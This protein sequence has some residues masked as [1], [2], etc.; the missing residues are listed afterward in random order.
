MIGN[1]LATRGLGGKAMVIGGLAEPGTYEAVIPA[2]WA[3]GTLHVLRGGGT[4]PTH[5]GPLIEDDVK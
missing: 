5:Q 1:R 3:M 2:R 4:L